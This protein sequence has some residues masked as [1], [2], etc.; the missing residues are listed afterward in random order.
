LEEEKMSKKNGE[1]GFF[2]I[3]KSD[4]QTLQE[5]KN[6]TKKTMVLIGIILLYTNYVRNAT[7]AGKA[8]FFSLC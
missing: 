5:A 3:L 4:P 2:E 6:K 7:N 8:P 1:K